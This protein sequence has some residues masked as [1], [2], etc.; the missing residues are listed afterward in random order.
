MR[1][2]E[3]KLVVRTGYRA[4]LY[5]TGPKTISP[6]TSQQLVARRSASA[7]EKTSLPAS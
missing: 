4:Y 1:D 2:V 6:K 3:D 7:I 5:S